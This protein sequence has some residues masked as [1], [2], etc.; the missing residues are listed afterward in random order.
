M[1]RSNLNFISENDIPAT[2]KMNLAG[3]QVKLQTSIDYEKIGFKGGLEIHAQLSSERK[4]F[5][6]CKPELIPAE[7]KPDYRFERR[8][9]PV[10]GE[11]GT[12]D[13]GMLVEFEKSYRVRYDTYGE[14]I[15]TYE[16]DET[17]PFH[18]DFETIRKGY[19]IGNFLNCRSAV[20]EIIFNRK[21]YLDGSIP[22]GFQRTAII[23]RDGH[24]TLKNGKKIRINNVLIEEDAARRVEFHDRA[25]R[26]VRFNLD[27]LGVPLTEIITNHEDCNN[28]FDLMNIGFL[29]GLSLRILEVGKRGIGTVRQDVN[30]SIKG[31]S[32]VELKGVQD[33][34][35]LIRYSEHEVTRQL[36]LIEIKNIL[37]SKGVIEDDFQPNFIDIS[38]SIIGN[39]S[40]YAFAVRLPK[41][42]GIFK[43]QVQQN[44]SFAEEIFDR[45]ELISGIS[46]HNMTT[47]DNDCSWL[48]NDR[49]FEI[50]NML[51]GDAFVAIC[52]NKKSVL[53]ALN[54][55]LE[56]MKLAL[57]GVPEE[58]RRVNTT[59]FNSEFL[60]VIH[61][62]DRM[63][64]DTDTPPISIDQKTREMKFNEILKIWDI[65]SQ[66]PVDIDELK[67]IVTKGF[68][69]PFSQLIKKYPEKTRS[70]LGLFQQCQSLIKKFSF[71]R[72]NLNQNGIELILEDIINKKISK[73]DLKILLSKLSSGFPYLNIKSEFTTEITKI[74]DDQIKRIKN[75]LFD[76]EK[77]VDI[78]LG[79]IFGIIKTN[80]PMLKTEQVISALKKEKFI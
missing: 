37:T 63:Y 60:R 52:G 21:Q 73:D 46:L 13:A 67:F 9:R 69:S 27:R 80:F 39:M 28:P 8:F 75:L 59:N 51:E 76:S 53:H 10:L 57:K 24:I 7:A 20:D 74:S 5:C 14:S 66:Y 77:T 4:L 61:G 30:I 56:R 34:E 11:M 19:I 41:C 15:C 40:K 2:I 58:T 35:N 23:A 43:K 47:S 36:A 6:H 49:V 38:S 18:P 22:T 31:G 44:K 33:L 32:R 12:F 54:R 3:N 68:Y 1:K 17:P 72:D 64:S 48:D 62:R 25:S 45:C 50:M 79:H 70:V 42:E 29:L 26:T 71:N 16:M 65:F 55:L 78:P